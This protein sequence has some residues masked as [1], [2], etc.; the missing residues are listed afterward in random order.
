GLEPTGL[1]NHLVRESPHV[2]SRHIA[3][4]GSRVALRTAVPGA[5]SHAA[6]PPATAQ[7]QKPRPLELDTARI[8]AILG[9]HGKANG[10]VYQLSI[11]RDGA[12][13]VDSVEIPPAMGVATAINFQ[14]IGPGKAATTGDFLLIASQGN[15]VIQAPRP[16]GMA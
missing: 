16:N 3:G 13:T 12:I 8:T 5:L 10:G 11:P 4:Q 6:T 2:V 9:A 14:S 1:H 7:P 15:P